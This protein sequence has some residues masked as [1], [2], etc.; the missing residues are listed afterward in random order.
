MLK[1]S[2]ITAV[3]NNQK[4]IKSAIDSVLSQKYPFV[5]YIVIDGASDDGTLNILNKNKANIDLL[6][7]EVD[8]GVYDAFNKGI[9]HATGDV[10]GFLHADDVYENSD[11]LTKIASVFE[12]SDN[13]ALYGDLV[14]VKSNNLKKVIRYWKAG[15]YTKKS[16]YRG[17]MP[18]HPTLFIR[19]SIYSKFGVFNSKYKISADYDLILRFLFTKKIKTS[20]IQ[21]VLVRM[22]SGGLSNRSFKNIYI[23]TSEDYLILKENK[24]GNFLTVFLKNL[25]KLNQFL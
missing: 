14:Y 18:P 12:N 8:G 25:R 19:K 22:R 3:Y 2:I 11:V 9:K 5:E 6:I 7:S 13:D 17:W 24:V 23:K 21:E 20:Y 4:T 10:I 1:I 16:F 15:N